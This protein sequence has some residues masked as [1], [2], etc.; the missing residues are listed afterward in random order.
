MAEQY[1]LGTAVWFEATFKSKDTGAV[2]D[3]SEVTVRVWQDGDAAADVQTSTYDGGLGQVVRE[4][5]GVYRLRTM[6]T[7]P[8]RVYA[9]FVGDGA[10]EA[11]AVEYAI[12]IDTGVPS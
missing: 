10:V 7:K 9:E 12:I 2:A 3:P 8:G 5:T 11:A 1:T 4:A 6:P